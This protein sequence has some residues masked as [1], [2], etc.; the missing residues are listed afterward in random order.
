MVETLLVGLLELFAD[1]L[2]QALVEGDTVPLCIF[3]HLAAVAVL[4]A[5]K[6]NDLSPRG[7]LT[8]F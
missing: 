3:D 4:A 8:T 2:G 5:F 7:P 1:D 6:I